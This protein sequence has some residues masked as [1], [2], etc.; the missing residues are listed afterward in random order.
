MLS[1]L[2]TERSVILKEL[3][4]SNV[5]GLTSQEMTQVQ[6]ARWQRA[7]ELHV[8][9]PPKLG[10]AQTAEEAERDLDFL[11]LLEK[12]LEHITEVGRE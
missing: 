10:Q 9:A 4:E 11:G 3:Q 7:L 8:Y 6:L 5:K 12:L 1:K 2:N